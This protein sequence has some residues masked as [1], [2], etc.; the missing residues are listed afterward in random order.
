MTRRGDSVVNVATHLTLLQLGHGAAGRGGATNTTLLPLLQCFRGWFVYMA[1]LAVLL[2][3]ELISV[4]TFPSRPPKFQCSSR[5]MLTGVYS[6]QGIARYYAD[7]CAQPLITNHPF[8][9]H[10]IL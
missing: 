10:V 9:L 8:H 3:P 6:L 4:Q 2:W 5:M 7:R 1:D